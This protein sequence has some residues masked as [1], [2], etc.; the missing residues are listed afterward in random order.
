MRRRVRVAFGAPSV[1]RL[2]R[3]GG[4]PAEE[5]IDPDDLQVILASARLHADALCVP[6]SERSLSSPFVNDVRHEDHKGSKLTGRTS[7][8]D[9]AIGMEFFE[10]VEQQGSSSDAARPPREAEVQAVPPLP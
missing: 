3:L 8:G 2:L 6:V 4:A 7:G 5:A 1:D 9:A 10:D